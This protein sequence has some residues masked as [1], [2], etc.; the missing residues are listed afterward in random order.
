MS[1]QSFTTRR[2]TMEEE[3]QTPRR[4]DRHIVCFMN[5]KHILLW[6]TMGIA[7]VLILALLSQSL[8]NDSGKLGEFKTETAND[9]KQV[10]GDVSTFKGVFCTTCPDHWLHFQKSCYFFSFESKPWKIAQQF[11]E[12]EDAHLVIVNNG[13]EQI[14]EQKYLSNMQQTIKDHEKIVQLSIGAFCSNKLYGSL[15]LKLLRVSGQKDQN[16]M[17]EN[18]FWGKDEPNNAGSGEDCATLR[19]SG[20]WNDAACSKNEFSICEKKC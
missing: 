7:F 17:N 10:H 3:L 15:Y 9:T 13:I 20:K 4:T 6:V 8:R 5:W 11:C 14:P 1:C 16:Q 18:S 19:F 2:L 12:N